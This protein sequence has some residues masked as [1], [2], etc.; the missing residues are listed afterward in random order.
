MLFLEAFP[1]EGGRQKRERKERER[2]KGEDRE[3]KEEREGKLLIQGMGRKCVM[4]AC[5]EKSRTKT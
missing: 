5:T 3:E 4:K 2:K 1:R